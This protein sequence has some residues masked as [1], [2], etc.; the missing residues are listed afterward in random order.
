MHA[1]INTRTDLDALKGGPDY[2]AAMQAILGATTTWVNVGT[3]DAPEWQLQ[4]MLEQIEM[5]GFETLE[6]VL[7]ECAAAGVSPAEAPPPPM[8]VVVAPTA[9]DV[10][11]ECSRRMCLL[12]GA[13]DAAGLAIKISNAM[14]ETLRLQDLRLRGI[15]WTAEETARAEQLRQADHDIERLRA[16]SNAMEPSPPDDYRDDAR[17]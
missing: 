16:C 17:W 4:T 5:L 8:R 11:A 13:T 3:N 10:R 7:A 9:N 14:R 2:A 12:V 1:I 6:A 15:D